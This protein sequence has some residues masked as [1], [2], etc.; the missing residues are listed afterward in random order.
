MLPKH[1]YQINMSV[2]GERLGLV[3]LT[4]HHKFE[5]EAHQNCDECW[6]GDPRPL[7]E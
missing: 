2:D 7:G 6:E 3:F 4:F 1:I 5:H